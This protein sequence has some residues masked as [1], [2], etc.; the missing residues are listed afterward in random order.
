[1]YKITAVCNAGVGSSAFCKGLIQKAVK[2]L[3]YNAKNF[4]IDC[5][6]LMGSK[7][8]RVDL[9]VTQKTLLEKVTKNVTNGGSSTPVVGVAS[10][11]SDIESMAE[12]L[13]PHLI[14][15]ERAGKISKE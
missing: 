13:R 10:L 15:A 8:L 11:V 3:G 7:G 6:E 5:T 1:M 4:S 12:A 9:I 2:S 14:D